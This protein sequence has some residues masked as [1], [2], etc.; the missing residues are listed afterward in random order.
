[1]TKNGS[2]IQAFIAGNVPA[3][4]IARRCARRLISQPAAGKRCT[5]ACA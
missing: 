5:E 1:L 3:F 2:E 4:V